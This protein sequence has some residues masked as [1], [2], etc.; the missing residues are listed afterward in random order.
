MRATRLML[1]SLAALALGTGAAS[2]Q[3]IAITGGTVY[4]VSGP[5]IENGTVLIR[6]GKVVAVGTDIAVPADA[7]RIDATG[8]WV[9]PGLVNAETQLGLFDVAFGGGTNDGSARGRGD[10]LT[11]SFTVW[12]GVNP[13]SVYIAPARQGGVTSVISSPGGNGIIAGQ[14]AML[15]LVDGGVS[16]ML[17]RAP[18]A[19]VANLDVLPLARVASR[20]EL[21]GR[22]REVL[23][24]TKAYMRNRAAFE[25]NATRAYALGRTDLEA[26]IPVVEGRIPL[27]VQASRASDIEAVLQLAREYSLRIILVGGAESW[28]VADK[29][30]AAKVPVLVGAMNNIPSSFNTL[31]QRQETAGL[32]RRAGISVAL[33]GNAGGGDEESFNVRNVKQEAGN[34]VAYGMSWD[35]ALRA[36]TLTPAELFG[37]SDRIGSLR[38]GREANVVVWSGDPFEFSTRAEHVLVRGREFTAPTRQDQLMQRYKKMPPDYKKP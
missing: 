18:T 17:V 38:P 2:A 36:V 37:V 29:I 25:R 30:A 19:M 9:T 27:A 31:G 10:A 15:D 21:F 4:P 33:I 22:L 32:L 8:K 6:D 16:D 24:D 14:A 13:R 20:G 11:P 28:M 7:R 34:A 3:T 5:K 35:D 1:A 12:E 23:E 26:M